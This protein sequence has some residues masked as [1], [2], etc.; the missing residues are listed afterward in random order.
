M[1]QKVISFDIGIKNLS[2][3]LF[4]YNTETD[5]IQIIQWDILNLTPPQEPGD[6][7]HH[8]TTCGQCCKKSLYVSPNE[9]QTFC[10][11]HAKLSPFFLPVLKLSSK[12]REELQQV[13]LAKGQAIEQPDKKGALIEHIKNNLLKKRKPAPKTAEVSL[14]D[15]GRQLNTLLS[16]RVP[17]QDIQFCLVENQ[18]G[19][20]ANRMKTIQGM[21]TEFFI[22]KT[23]EAHIEYI[24]SH[25]KL[26][27]LETSLPQNPVAPIP[28][29][30]Q[31]VLPTLRLLPPPPASRPSAK[32]PEVKKGRSIS[33]KNMELVQNEI[34]ETEPVKKTSNYANNK[35]QSVDLVKRICPPSHSDFFLS[36]KKKDDLADCFLQ[37]VWFVKVKNK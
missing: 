19:N 17:L 9:D 8:K 20:L 22:I 13:V 21:V 4:D 1:V 26:K 31:V 28:L 29:L 27:V 3:C 23:P 30:Q 25:N 36:H 15:I 10:E 2:Y 35:K 34:H 16:E 12:T 7:P 32:Q 33:I 24:S 5:Q 14:I 37:G 11:K 6:K 18:I